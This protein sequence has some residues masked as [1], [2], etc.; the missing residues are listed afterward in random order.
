MMTRETSKGLMRRI[1]QVALAAAVVAALGSCASN[2]ATG[3]RDLVFMSEKDEIELGRK[4]HPQI[5]TQ[6]KEY[7]DPQLKAYVQEIG[8]RIA[9]QS[10]RPN[11]E[12]TFTLL[13]SEEVNAFATPGGF[14][15][16]SRGLLAYLNSEAELA[17]VLG[18]EIAHVTAR[19]SVRQHAGQKIGEAVGV[20]ASVAT[21][22]WLAGD[23]TGV[24]SKALT[25]G[26]GRA[27][28]LEADELGAQYLARTGYPHTAMIDVV[29]LLKHQEHFEIRQAHEEGRPPRV[30]HG[31]FASHPDQ[32]T[33]LQEVVEAAAELQSSESAEANRY[34]F[35][36][37]MD[38]VPFGKKVVTGSVSVRGA[39]VYN[40]ALG[41]ALTVPRGWRV[42]TLPD[43]MV[44]T[45]RYNDGTITIAVQGA[46]K[47]YTPQ[48]FIEQ[49]LRIDTLRDGEPLNHGPPAYTGIVPR[50]ASPYGLTDSRLAV[51]YFGRRA[52]VFTGAAA[53]KTD[54]RKYDPE[55]FALLN[56]LRE[57]TPEE[58]ERSQQSSIRLTQVAPGTTVETLAKDSSIRRYPE[59][60]LRLING[61]YPDKQPVPGDVIKTIE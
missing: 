15:Y 61:L 9:K 56:S 46:S 20:V 10:H 2:P 6:Y 3:G 29:R 60:T 16:I 35:L 12:Y 30:Y 13:D 47:S 44:A 5:M 51:V 7:N 52:Y 38:G 59:E 4:Y 21:G 49:R 53:D 55:F 25:S 57:L 17:A 23:A 43:R 42:Q 32:D 37:Y 18:H 26:Y 40:H 28:E 36:N 19:H 58:A 39:N 33:R 50:S 34:E 8:E 27:M 31:V 22:T 11:L 14:I 24:V 1:A 45:S 48:E 54:T 41:V